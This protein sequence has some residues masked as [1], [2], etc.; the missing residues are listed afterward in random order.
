MQ[1]I[2]QAFHDLILKID[3]HYRIQHVLIERDSS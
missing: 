3:Y 2:F 1:E